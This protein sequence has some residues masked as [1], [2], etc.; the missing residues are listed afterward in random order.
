MSRLFV[1]ATTLRMETLISSAV[2]SAESKKLTAYHEAGHA[3]MA[4]FTGGA[5]PVHKA[6]M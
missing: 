6:T 2:I 1:L 5:T 4:M 3:V